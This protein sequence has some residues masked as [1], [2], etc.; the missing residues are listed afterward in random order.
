VFI[1][2][3]QVNVDAA[4]AVGLHALRFQSASQCQQEF[5]ELLNAMKPL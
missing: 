5:D 2:D 3:L 4:K 1:D